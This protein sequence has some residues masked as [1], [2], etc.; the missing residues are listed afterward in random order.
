[1]DGVV[2]ITCQ[3]GWVLCPLDT[4]R[5]AMPWGVGSLSVPF[6]GCSRE[7][8]CPF[9]E[10]RRIPTAACLQRGL[11]LACNFPKVCRQFLAGS[12]LAESPDRFSKKGTPQR[13]TAPGWRQRGGAALLPPAHRFPPPPGLQLVIRFFRRGPSS[14]RSHATYRCQPGFS[15]ASGCAIRGPANQFG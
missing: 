1:M 6:P 14:R 5:L 15:S 10:F 13:S 4:C 7:A 2:I 11:I 8:L 12:L 9:Q 3:T